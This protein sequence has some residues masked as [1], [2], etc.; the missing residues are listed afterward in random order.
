MPSRKPFD[1]FAFLEGQSSAWG[2]F[3]DRSGTPKRTFEIT[4]EGRWDGDA[5]I[6]DEAFQYDDGECEARR[7]TFKPSSDAQTTERGIASD[8]IGTCP[9]CVGTAKLSLNENSADMKYVFR[10]KLK[11]RS[12]DLTF[13]DRFFPIGDLGV[14]NR[15][16]VSKFGIRVGEVT[17]FFGRG[18]I[19]VANRR[20]ELVEQMKMSA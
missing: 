3:E 1:L 14:M 6:L 2:L 20:P 9:E 16:D 8:W 19:G 15:T 10:L 17:A 4:T 7:W 18:Q 5:F 12:I 11:S 13:H